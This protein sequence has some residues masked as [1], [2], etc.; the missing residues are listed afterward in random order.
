VA[1]LMVQVPGGFPSKTPRRLHNDGVII[2]KMFK[3]LGIEPRT[4]EFIM[5]FDLVKFLSRINDLKNGSTL[6]RLLCYYVLLYSEF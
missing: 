3:W 1:L 2:Y 6:E 5:G 4:N